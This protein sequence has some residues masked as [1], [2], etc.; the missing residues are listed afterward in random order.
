MFTE[1]EAVAVWLAE[2][3]TVQRATPVKLAPVNKVALN[4]VALPVGLVI[5]ML[6]PPL[7]QVHA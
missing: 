5:V 4:A 6:A 1:T 2:S 3:V 7:L